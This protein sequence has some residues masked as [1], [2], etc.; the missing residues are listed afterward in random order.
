MLN[1]VMHWIPCKSLSKIKAAGL[2]LPVASHQ[3]PR[4][5]RAPAGTADYADQACGSTKTR[6]VGLPFSVFNAIHSGCR[7][8]APIDVS[9]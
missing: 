2:S 6:L 3:T 5:V 9:R 7:H 1:T 8:K 4:L